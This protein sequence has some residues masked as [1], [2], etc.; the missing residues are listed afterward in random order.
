MDSLEEIYFNYNLAMNQAR[1]LDE[2]AGRLDKTANNDMERIL[3]E[4][5][6]AWKSQQTAP[7]YIR[8]GQKVEGDI[9]TT[10]ENLRNIA[11]TIRTIAERVKAAELAA[12]EI[13]NARN[14]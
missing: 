4:V 5:S 10:A 6:R 9:R 1:Q 7:Q 12:W 13:A 2:V 8:K 14:S 11:T 3:G